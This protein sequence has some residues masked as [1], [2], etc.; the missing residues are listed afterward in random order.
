M[1]LLK[2]DIKNTG[3]RERSKKCRPFRRC[4]NLK[5]YLIKT[6]RYIYRSTYMNLTITTNQKPII[7]TQN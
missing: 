4:S 7:D 5:D 3:M 6:N 2:Y 1:K